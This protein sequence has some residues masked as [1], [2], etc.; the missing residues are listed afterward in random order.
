MIDTA[1]KAFIQQFIKYYHV[2][3]GKLGF[4]CGKIES[5]TLSCS[6]CYYG[7]IRSLDCMY[8]S[9]TTTEIISVFPEVLL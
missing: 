1:H 2:N 5:S 3:E 4:S 6:N 8:T 7:S 9:I